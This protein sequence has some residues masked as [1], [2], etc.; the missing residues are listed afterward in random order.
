MPPPQDHPAPVC[1]Q[2]QKNLTSHEGEEQASKQSHT[3]YFSL[4]SHACPQPPV[5]SVIEEENRAFFTRLL[6]RLDVARG[7][8]HVELHPTV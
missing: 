3:H 4:A 1:G 2:K 8:K 5:S 6:W 7:V